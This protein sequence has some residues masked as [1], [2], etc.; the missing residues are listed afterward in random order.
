MVKRSY[1]T[2]ALVWRLLKMMARLLPWISLAVICALLG[3]LV[4]IVVPSSLAYLA[5]EAFKGK[6]I[7]FD[8]LYGFI[9]LAF[10]RG[11]FR[12]GEHY[13]G[14][15]VAFHSLAEFRRIIFSKLRALTPGHLDRQDSGHLLK[16]IG[17]DI[18]ALEI[19][20]AH[21][22]APVITALLSAFFILTYFGT[23]SR[24]LSLLAGISYCLLALVIP[25]LFA[26]RL[27]PLLA[28]Q[29]QSRRSY[30]SHF[31]ENLRAVRD[32]LQYHQMPR[33]LKRI[34][35]KSKIVNDIDR[36]VGQLQ[37]LHTATTFL[38]L[39][40]AILAFSLVALLEVNQEA[41]IYEEALIA[42]VAF[43]A[44]FSPFL[45][46]GRLP[47]A[48]KRSMNAARNIFALLDEAAIEDKGQ[49]V[50]D[51]IDSIKIDHLSFSYPN[52]REFVYNKL[53][54]QLNDKGII[55]IKG[56]SG[57]GKTTLAK[58]LMK[59]YN[60]NSGDIFL[61]GQNS[62]DLNAAQLQSR[63]AYV[64]QNPQ[65]FQQSLRENL[66]LGRTDIS[67]DTIL[68]LAKACGLK[69]RI[70]A[71]EQG[72]DTVIGKVDFFS[73][74]EKQRL[75]L[76]RALLKDADAYIFDEPTSHLDSLNEAILIDL[77]RKHCSGFVFLIS[78]RASTLA[79]AD[80]VFELEKGI[81]K[82]V[83]SYE[84]FKN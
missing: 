14:H 42:F 7:S 47:L 69:E 1:K 52:S 62:L 84:T 44:S 81:L 3:L 83:T 34:A 76:M 73:A 23:M 21:T 5:L 20:F 24:S 50:L 53:T 18:E 26:K 79:C 60:W 35:R 31:L 74:G 45:E 9:I 25:L 65:L 12:Y 32:L 40:L 22:I 66:R 30:M 72:L 70:L 16:M 28:Q 68:D 10:L 56:Q 4:T 64:P 37:W 19:F 48:F 46:L 13:F 8:Y 67:D 33:E 43:T 71:C 36:K 59:W 61:S 2:Y 6:S 77:I 11:L 49:E 75:E 15:F 78:H 63:F 57:S 51:S 41:L 54:L 27:E 39:G 58:I 29:N 38:T 55:G 17:E 80:Q 82:E